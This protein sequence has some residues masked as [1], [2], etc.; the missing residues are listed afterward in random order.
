[1]NFIVESGGYLI[2]IETKSAQTMAKDFFSNLK[3]R[4]K[5]YGDEEAPSALIYGG[6][7]SYKVRA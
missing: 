6:D 2:P 4:K 3:H 5:L 7:R 1:V